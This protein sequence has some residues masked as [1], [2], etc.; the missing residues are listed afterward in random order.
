M[1]F[2]LAQKGFFRLLTY[3]MGY[4][5]AFST[6]YTGRTY[7]N[8]SLKDIDLSWKNLQMSARVAW[9]EKQ[10]AGWDTI[11]NA[12]FYCRDFHRMTP[13]LRSQAIKIL[14]DWQ[15]AERIL[16]GLENE[17]IELRIIGAFSLPKSS[18][19][20]PTAW[21]KIVFYK[22]N[23]FGGSYRKFEL[24]T[25]AIQKTQDP[26]WNQTFT[27]DI[28]PDARMIDLEVYDRVAGLTDKELSRVRL[29]FSSIAGIE[30]TFADKS[31]IYGYDGMLI[32]PLYNAMHKLTRIVEELD[33]PLSII[34]G[35]GKEKEQPI[36][37]IG[38]QWDGRQSKV[39]KLG[40]PTSPP[41]KMFRSDFV[42]TPLSTE[43]RAA[44][45]SGAAVTATSSRD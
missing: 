8:H 45:K 18:F 10:L 38:L 29:K 28:P 39:Q 2:E 7:V 40:L 36:L 33:F 27:L 34:D 1:E 20:V 41:G 31:L 21:V 35:K 42:G 12:A 24:K 13:G 30:A 32:V 3:V 15:A 16:S 44:S 6:I 9:V 19:R 25:D 4:M 43:Q 23:K 11:Q 14:E 37:R 5:N 26:V 17:H 22:P